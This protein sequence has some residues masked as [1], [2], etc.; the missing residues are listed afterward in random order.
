M[1]RIRNRRKLQ[2]PAIAA[3]ARV[4]RRSKRLHKSTNRH[5]RRK[6]SKRREKGS[7]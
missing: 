6:L 1:S 4:A 3:V 7:V 5:R 2:L